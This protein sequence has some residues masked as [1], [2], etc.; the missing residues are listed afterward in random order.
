MTTRGQGND[1]ATMDQ[2]KG[3]GK[4]PTGPPVLIWRFWL[5]RSLSLLAKSIRAPLK[6][7][8]MFPY[9]GQSAAE[10]KGPANK[11][12]SIEAPPLD[13]SRRAGRDS[14]GHRSIVYISFPRLPARRLLAQMPAP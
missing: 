12:G 2:A 11:S 10:S 9:L 5:R 6:A 4:A 7:A 1:Q 8:P 14:S 3:C 13:P